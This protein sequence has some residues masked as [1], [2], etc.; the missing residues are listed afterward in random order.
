MRTIIVNG[1]VY[2]NVDPE[3]LRQT[4]P[5]LTFLS[6]FTYGITADG[7]LVQLDD[8]S[9]IEIA[10]AYGVGP[11]MVLAALTE[12]GSFN[13]DV[14]SA[15]F[16]SEAAQERLVE[17]ILANLVAKNLAGVD[18]DF[19]FVYPQ[20]RDAYTALVDRTRRRLNP[21]GY[22]VTATLAPKTSTDQQGLLYEGHDYYGMGQAANLVLVM[23]YEWGYT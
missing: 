23:T 18:F 4:A 12:D 16:Q 10:R 9:V 3:V 20:D 14:A 8:E 13:S 21:L 1:Y 7:G 22:I 6:L 5:N 19:E 15:V 2:P 17:E 11:L